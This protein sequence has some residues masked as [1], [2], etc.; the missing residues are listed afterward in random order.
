M[1]GVEPPVAGGGVSH[2]VHSTLR[3]NI[4]EHVFIGE[5][6]R[7]LWRWGVTD[8]EVLRSEFDAGGYDLV[9]SH[10]EITRHVQLKS[11]LQGGRA[12]NFKVGTKLEERPSGCVVCIFVTKSLEIVGFSFFGN[13]AGERLDEIGSLAKAKHTKCNAQGVKLYRPLHRLIPR[14]D[15]D[16]VGTMDALIGKLLGISRRLCRA[17]P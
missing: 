10:G 2:S 14:R 13:E 15:F 17:H 7:T 1:R 5:L 6:L 3:E 11:V 12:A 4:L 9:I 8:V 16:P